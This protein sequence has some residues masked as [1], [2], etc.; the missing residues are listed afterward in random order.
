MF[1]VK[2]KDTLLIVSLLTLGWQSCSLAQVREVYMLKDKELTREQYDAVIL[3]KDGIK[4]LKANDNIGAI[5]SF[6]H[7]ESLYP[8]FQPNQHNLGVALAKMGKT[9][10]A[11]TH[12]ETARKLN[13]NLAATWLSLAGMY[14]NDGRIKDAL[15]TYRE[16][17]KRFPKDP[18]A[19]K[20]K[21]LVK[22]LTNEAN[23]EQNP[24]T[25]IPESK[26][27][28]LREVTRHGLV[29][30]SK[31]KMPLRVYVAPGNSVPG[32]KP[33]FESSLIQSFKDWQK[34]AD[35]LVSFKFV[36]NEMH[37]DIQCTWTN[38]PKDL[39][40][41]A[42]A[43]ECRLISGKEGIV[44]GTIKLLTCPHP[45]MN[46]LPLTGNRMRLICLHE[47]GHALGLSGHT[48]NPN[49][50]MFYSI[51]ASDEW[52]NLTERDANTIKKLYTSNESL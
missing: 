12:F 26:T 1:S 9:K 13:P 24:N 35:N 15:A 45:S 28:Y 41:P 7:A 29:K 5:Q 20:V 37:S 47:I 6:K 18:T 21:N 2:L 43:G 11:I 42:E 8:E 23:L 52:R 49:D 25:T 36:E 33:E 34:A 32:Y 19:D 4:K 31:V 17:L 44:K 50:V 16:Y 46:M 14:Q 3:Y 30:W 22:G 38:N 10:E 40:N 27:D 51:G 48:R 39:V